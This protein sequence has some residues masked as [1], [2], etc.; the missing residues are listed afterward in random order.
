MRNLALIAI[1]AVL[2]GIGMMGCQTTQ[3]ATDTDTTPTQQTQDDTSTAVVPDE[4]DEDIIV[5]S[6]DDQPTE[7]SGAGDLDLEAEQLSDIYFDFDSY[8]IR[9]MY[10]DKL[11]AL[12]DLL[13]KSGASVLIEG[14]CDERGTNEYNLALGD[15]RANAV[16]SFLKASGVP[17]SRVETISFGE[18]KP[19]CMESGEN[20][21][22]RNRRSHVVPEG[23]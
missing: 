14:H 18:E 1:I 6:G 7:V 19:V 16:K 9:P 15:R 8:E 4:T 13:L 11:I 10:K 20:C 3:V 22:S 5:E 17:T 12:S 2:F 21:W 23:M